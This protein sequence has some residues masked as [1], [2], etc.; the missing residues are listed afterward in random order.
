MKE[1]KKTEARGLE[2]HQNMMQT[3]TERFEDTAF[4]RGFE[5]STDPN[6]SQERHS[7][8]LIS[9]EAA[10]A[11]FADVLKMKTIVVFDQQENRVQVDVDKE[12]LHTKTSR[13]TLE[14]RSKLQ[15][16]FLRRPSDIGSPSLRP[17]ELGSPTLQHSDVSSPL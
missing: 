13:L 1:K 16:S 10:K 5:S 15:G 7:D 9:D 4:G 17:S 11:P 3:F 12:L 2:L 6:E 14:D 8:S